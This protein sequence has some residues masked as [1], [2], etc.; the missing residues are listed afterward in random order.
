M[1]ALYFGDNLDVLRKHVMDESVDLVYL[2]PPFNSKRDYN[3]IF[4][5][6]TGA[7]PASQ[8]HAFED[9]WHWN[10][11]GIDGVIPFDDGANK[12]VKRIIVQVKGGGNISVIDVR[13]LRGTVERE[14]A[15]MGFLLLANEP[16]KPMRDEAAQA[17][18]FKSE[19]WG[20]Y[21]K[22]QIRTVEDLFSGKPFEHPRQAVTGLKAAPK[23]QQQ[24]QMALS[25]AD[26]DPF[27]EA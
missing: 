16:T 12:Q 13:D 23:A 4:K 22:L 27:A 19:S 20:T 14:Q 5:E 17:G 21:P 26:D 10:D 1:N 15:A 25:E 6:A 2:D 9:S 18:V 7:L 8:M 11:R 24:E 3:V